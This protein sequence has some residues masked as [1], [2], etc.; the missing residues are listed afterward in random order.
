MATH[1]LVPFRLTLNAINDMVI[2]HANS[3][4]VYGRKCMLCTDRQGG[5]TSSSKCQVHIQDHT[6]LIKKLS[7]S[8]EEANRIHQT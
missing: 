3:W 1:R 2:V 7:G 5:V 8:V 6:L 4:L